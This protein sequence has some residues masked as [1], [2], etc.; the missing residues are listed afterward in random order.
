M[1]E[2]VA[3]AGGAADVGRMPG[4]EVASGMELRRSAREVRTEMGKKSCIVSASVT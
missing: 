2:L 4:M 3:V 1:D